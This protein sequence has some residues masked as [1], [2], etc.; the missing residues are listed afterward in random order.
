MRPTRLEW[1]TGLSGKRRRRGDG[2]RSLIVRF[3]SVFAF[4]I[5]F[6][7]GTHTPRMAHGAQRT[8]GVEGF[9]CLGFAR[10]GG[11]FLCLCL[12]TPSE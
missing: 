11:G 2:H 12:H 4:S 8:L 9:L 5:P 6:V 1:T 3:I 7:R 10:R